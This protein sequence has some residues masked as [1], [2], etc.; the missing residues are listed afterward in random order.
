MSQGSSLTLR[1]LSSESLQAVQSHGLDPLTQNM[2]GSMKK[3]VYCLLLWRFRRPQ[4]AMYDNASS[5]IVGRARLRKSGNRSDDQFCWQPYDTRGNRSR[6]S[7]VGT[8][9]IAEEL[10]AEKN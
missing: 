1:V 2:D 9:S 8:D 7:R 4:S 5:L 6:A 10:P 3:V